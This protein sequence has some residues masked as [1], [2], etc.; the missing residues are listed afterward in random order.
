MN[1]IKNHW[2]VHHLPNNRPISI[3]AIKPKGSN[4]PL[5][6]QNRTYH[7]SDYDSQDELKAAFEQGA[8]QLN[9]LGYNVYTPMNMICSD[10]YGSAAVRDAD[11]THRTKV[12]VDIDRVG[13]TSCP[14]SDAEIDAAFDMG[15][16]VERFLRGE[17][18]PD[19]Q[20]VHSGNGCHLYYQLLKLQESPLVKQTIEQFLKG[21]AEKFNNSIVGVDI[22]VF[23]ASR[24][25]KVIGTFARKGIESEG[26][27]YRMAR[28]V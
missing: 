7:P 12:L 28:L 14:A 25:T 15:G 17:G 9:N 21:L 23:N 24:I 20:W 16:D 1:E 19:P 27:P 2:L 5:V 26:R 4:R 18:F 10:F 8:I 22:S 13:D 3:R 11:I 6:P